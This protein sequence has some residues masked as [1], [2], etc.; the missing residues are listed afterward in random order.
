LHQVDL[1]GR[2]Q[3]RVMARAS[4]GLGLYGMA[5]LL[6]YQMEPDRRPDEKWYGIGPGEGWYKRGTVGV[7]DLAAKWRPEAGSLALGAGVTIGTVSDNG[8]TFAGRV[9]LVIV[10]PGPI[11][12][13]EG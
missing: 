3:G 9:L 8:F 6:A 4:T 10:F 7:T 2:L 12:M 11:I 5:G 1:L 13:L